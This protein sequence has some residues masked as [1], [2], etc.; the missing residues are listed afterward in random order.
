[1]QQQLYSNLIKDIHKVSS[2]EVAETAKLL[3]NTYRFINIAF[4][5]KWTQICNELN[6]NIWEVIDAS[7]TKPFGFQN[8]ILV[9]A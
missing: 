3:E 8:S 9:L 6:I 5:M 7:G 2:P 1:M 4:T